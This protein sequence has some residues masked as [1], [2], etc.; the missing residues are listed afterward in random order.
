ML[1]GQYGLDPY[2]G[3]ERTVEEL[4]DYC[5]AFE[6]RMELV[7]LWGYNLAQGV[8]SMVLSREKPRPE[9]VFPGWIKPKIMTDEEL[10]A[11]L[12]AWCN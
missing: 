2:D 7:S 10:W 9:Q 8:A 5:E 11:N 3:W 1:A 6:K 12:S 4:L